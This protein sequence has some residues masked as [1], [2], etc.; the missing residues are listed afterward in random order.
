MIVRG[1]YQSIDFYYIFQ[2]TPVI[3]NPLGG[4]YRGGYPALINPLWWQEWLVHYDD[5]FGT[6]E[7]IIDDPDLY[8]MDLTDEENDED[9]E[10]I[11]FFWEDYDEWDID[12]FDDE[13][14]ALFLFP[15]TFSYY[16]SASTTHVAVRFSWIDFL[17]YFKEKKDQYLENIRIVFDFFLLFFYLI[18]FIFFDR[19][20]VVSPRFRQK[21]RKLIRVCLVG[22]TPIE[23]RLTFGRRFYTSN[24]F[25]LHLTY[26][27]YLLSDK[28]LQDHASKGRYIH[29]SFY[30]HL[31]FSVVDK[32]TVKINMKLLRYIYF[33]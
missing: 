6:D 3:E 11:F 5:P 4:T 25:S 19:N 23:I 14:E 30:P 17:I 9:E 20:L 24:F 33:W 26:N 31:H 28:F 32:R 10:E 15:E 29:L 18:Q 13:E 7:K 22:M 27:K 16:L 12:E 8:E 2:Y 1:T 21:R